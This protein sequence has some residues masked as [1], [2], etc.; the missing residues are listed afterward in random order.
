MSA[1]L[2]VGR[3]E[4]PMDDST[5]GRHRALRRFAGQWGGPPPGEGSGGEA[6]RQRRALHKLQH[7]R[8]KPGASSIP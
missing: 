1:N 2:D 4:I 6:I 3:L 7:E 5:L 8:W